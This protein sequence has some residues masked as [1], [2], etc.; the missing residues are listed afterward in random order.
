MCLKMLQFMRFDGRT[1]FKALISKEIDLN[2]FF[3]NANVHLFCRH[4]QGRRA[5][6]SNY[7]SKIAW[8]RCIHCH[9]FQLEERAKSSLFAD[10]EHTFVS[11]HPCWAERHWAES[12]PFPAELI[13][14]EAMFTF[15][16]I[17]EKAAKNL[18]K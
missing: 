18:Q 8:Y 16:K 11:I 9:K 2:V 12:L 5:L 6:A 1:F 14:M 15:L 17:K 10:N 7:Q 4:R 13:S 3:F